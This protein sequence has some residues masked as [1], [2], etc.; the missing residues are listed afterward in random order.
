MDEELL[1]DVDDGVG[2]LTL[3]RPGKR[4]AL[5]WELA[6]ELLGRFRELRDRDEI[7][8]VVL[9]GAGGAFCAG[10]DA[11]WIGGASDRPLPGVTDLP[12]PRLQRKFPA[13]P[14]H[15]LPRAMLGLDKPL[16]AAISGVAVGAGLSL[17][18][19]CD[20]R[21]AEPGARLGTA[22]V[23]IAATPDT[24]LSY[25]LPRVV[26]ISTAIMMVSTGK[27]LDANDALA[28]GLVDEVATGQTALEAASAYARQLASGPSVAIDLARRL[29]YKSLGAS[30]DEMLDYEEILGTVA[31]ATDDF[32]E[33]TRS[34]LEKRQP[35][36]KG[37]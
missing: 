18:L 23:H 26:G 17:A 3:N 19:A 12:I 28:A 8:A 5:S 4:N 6:T 36:W 32:R 1:F 35:V 21:F 33:G 7:R 25:F 20:R 13:G 30:L 34:F 15:Q 14:F 9:T 2:I 37:Q 11:E 10:A 16:L 31:S 29:I 22:F 24:G 27:M